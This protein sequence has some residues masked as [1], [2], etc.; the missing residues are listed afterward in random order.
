VK[1][2]PFYNKLGYVRTACEPFVAAHLVKPEIECHSIV[3]SKAL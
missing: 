3:M 2:V 1:L